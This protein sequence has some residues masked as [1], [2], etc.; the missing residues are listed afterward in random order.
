M[1]FDQYC[2]QYK[3]ATLHDQFRRYVLDRLAEAKKP[4]A[5]IDRLSER[6]LHRYWERYRE[7]VIKKNRWDL[8]G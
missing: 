1:T 4:E 3:I 2:N 6:E 8:G 7:T 5:D